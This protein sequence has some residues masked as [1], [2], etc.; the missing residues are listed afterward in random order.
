M[1][2]KKT[3]TNANEVI[4]HIARNDF[5]FKPKEEA[6]KQ[7]EEEEI[8]VCQPGKKAE[9]LNSVIELMHFDGHFDTVHG[10]YFRNLIG[11]VLNVQFSLNR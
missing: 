5:H 1:A 4:T 3:V 10:Q 7:K 8:N 6:E 9:H 11:K 2:I